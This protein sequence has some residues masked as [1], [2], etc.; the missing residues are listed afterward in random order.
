MWYDFYG[1]QYLSKIKMYNLQLCG[2]LIFDK[3]G[4]NIQWEKDSLF[5]KWYWENWTAT[6]RRIKLDYFLTPYTKINSKWMKDLNVRLEIIKILKEN[7]GS[8]LFD[9]S[10]VTFLLDVSPE[11]RETKAKI[12]YWDFIKVKTSAQ[13]RKQSTKLKGS[14]QNG[15][16]YLE[17][18]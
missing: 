4:K 10:Q 14:L 5:N 1:W 12:N 11:A 18:I 16:R 17:M 7:P 13:R 2:Q 9:T 15:R 6:C 3:A 8:N